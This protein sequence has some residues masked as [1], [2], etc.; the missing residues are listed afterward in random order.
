M[1]M[2][3]FRVKEQGW[4]VVITTTRADPDQ[5]FLPSASSAGEF[6]AHIDAL[7]A[8]LERVRA[9]GMRKAEHIEQEV[10]RPKPEKDSPHA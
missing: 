3:F 8:D 6:S 9:I 10:F 2:H 5:P 4:G 7:I 1:A